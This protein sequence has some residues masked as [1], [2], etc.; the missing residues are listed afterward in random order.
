MPFSLAR[1]FNNADII[2]AVN[3]VWLFQS[4]EVSHA[5]IRAFDGVTPSSCVRWCRKGRAAP[6]RLGCDIYLYKALLTST[7]TPVYQS[8]VDRTG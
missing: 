4:L 1:V 2:R 5:A 7:K 6:G 8:T 3:D